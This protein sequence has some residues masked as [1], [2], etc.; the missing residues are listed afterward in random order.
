LCN[1]FRCV[2][3]DLRGHGDSEWA[4]NYAINAH[5]LDLCA[6][7]GH[8]RW[9]SVHLVG[10]SL[11]AVIAAHYAATGDSRIAS[12]TMVDTGPK[13]DFEQTAG[14]RSFMARPIAHL[15]LEQLAEAAV[16]V[17]GR[18]KYNKILYRYMHMTSTTAN[19]RL[20]WRHDQRRRRPSDYAYILN[21]IDEL[22]L[23]APA[24]TCKVL[25]ARG[26]R[27]RIITDE[28]VA[29]FAA[30]FHDARATTISDAGHNVQEDNPVA[31]GQALREF[32]SPTA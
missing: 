19:G 18:D 13:P 3:V 27:S 5:L 29:A 32:L 20:A 11:G 24:M 9:T 10:M 26:G 28:N 25:I 30:R 8:F 16:K 17:A 21:K 15:T 14:M 7:I 1:E 12:L 6:V 22:E 2:A 31:L 23:L 4:G